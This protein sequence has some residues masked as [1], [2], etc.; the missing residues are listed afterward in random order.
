MPVKKIEK[1][2]FLLRCWE[3]FHLKGYHA[4]SMQD[5]AQATGLQ[6]AGLYHHFATKQALMQEVLAY[7]STQF[8]RYVL[9]VAHETDLPPEQRLEKMLRRQRRLATLHRRGCFFANIALET[10]RDGLFNA[11]LQA[12]FQAWKTNLSQVLTAFFSPEKAEQESERL[13]MEYEGAVVFYKIS[14]D[15]NYLEAF[16]VRTIRN[17]GYTPFPK[18]RPS[19]LHRPTLSV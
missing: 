17:L 12:L 6:K 15:E 13:M 16:I 1:S 2:D 14:G 19:S 5:L 11:E 8:Q 10:G 9:S 7:A 4:T 18:I 3:V